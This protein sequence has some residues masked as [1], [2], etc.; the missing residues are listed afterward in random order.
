LSNW[1][2]SQHFLHCNNRI[3]GN[4]HHLQP[5]QQVITVVYLPCPH[6]QKEEITVEQ[7]SF[8]WSHINRK[9]LFSSCLSS[10]TQQ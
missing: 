2:L 3:T 7:L 10:V 9:S 8:F 6:L 4:D 1:Q 5:Q